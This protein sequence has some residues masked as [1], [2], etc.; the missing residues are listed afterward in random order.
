MEIEYLNDVKN[1]PSKY[2]TGYTATNK[3]ITL[4]EILELE[5]KYNN[6]NYFPKS[7]RE[8]L[9]LA[10]NYCNV[11]DYGICKSQN[12]LQELVKEN[13]E[14]ENINLDKPFY[15][16]DV[17]IAG[18]QFFFVYLDINDNPPV[19]EGIINFKDNKIEIKEI[20]ESLSKFLSHLIE[21]E[22]EDIERRN[23]K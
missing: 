12:E 13:L 23:Q 22:K 11:L 3:P 6:G 18:T 15:I 10:G 9:F 21:L 20:S 2:S 17:Y 1:Y 5:K 14:E 4:I 16:I 7:L 8:L 19:Y